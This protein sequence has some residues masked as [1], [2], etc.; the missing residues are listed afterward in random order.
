[1]VIGKGYDMGLFNFLFKNKGKELSKGN[2]VA[3][4]MVHDVKMDD[5]NFDSIEIESANHNGDSIK[6]K[7]SYYDCHKIESA[8]MALD[9][10]NSIILEGDSIKAYLAMGEGKMELQNIWKCGNLLVQYYEDIYAYGK[11]S[12]SDFFRSKRYQTKEDRKTAIFQ[13]I[14]GW[15]NVNLMFVNICVTGY[16]KES[17]QIKPLAK[18]IN[19]LDI[20]NIINALYEN[21]K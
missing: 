20:P 10:L 3:K 12:V 19:N 6:E 16:V 13:I 7:D 8:I 15:D 1:L 18:Q 21:E 9:K 2:N 14:E 5:M 4:R 17:I 11:C